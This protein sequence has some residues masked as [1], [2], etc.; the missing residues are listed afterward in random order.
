MVWKK[1]KEVKNGWTAYK[2]D[3]ISVD[4][5]NKKTYKE[6]KQDEN[7]ESVKHTD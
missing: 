4:A 3:G 2:E 6:I 1:T 5:I 7:N